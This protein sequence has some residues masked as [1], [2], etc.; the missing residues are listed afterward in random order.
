LAYAGQELCLFL[1]DENDLEECAQVQKIDLVSGIMS[2]C[3]VEVEWDQV[4][5]IIVCVDGSIHKYTVKQTAVTKFEVAHVVTVETGAADGY[6]VVVMPDALML[7]KT[8]NKMW[9]DKSTKSTV[10]FV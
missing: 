3:F 10:Y 6:S 9:A 2:T 8:P 1:L 5:L 7:S 4:E